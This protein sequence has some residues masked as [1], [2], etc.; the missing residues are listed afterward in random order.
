MNWTID[1][2]EENAASIE[3]P[4][5]KMIHLPVSLLPK[6]AKAGQMLRVT[7]EIDEAATKR[8]RRESSSQVKKISD[9]SQKNDP[10]GDINL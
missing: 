7:L 3:L 6:G 10:G 5:G 2:I 8:A 4:D 1:S 9:E